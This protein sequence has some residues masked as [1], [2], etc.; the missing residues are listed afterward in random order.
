MQPRPRISVIIPTF[1]SGMFLREAVVSVL[2]QRGA[3]VEVI[4]VDDASTDGGIET[5]THLER[6]T[7]VRLPHNQGAAAAQNIGL[8]I[9]SG[10][11]ITFLDS[12]DR[13]AEN[14]LGWRLDWIQTRPKY[15]VV[16]GMAAGILDDRG[17]VV[18]DFLH[19]NDVSVPER[20]T[21]QFYSSG[22]HYPVASWLYLFRKDLVDAVGPFDESLR[23]AYD[24]DFLL[25]VLDKTDIPMVPKATVYRRIHAA[26]ISVTRDWEG[27][28]L[29]SDTIEECRRVLLPRGIAPP[30]EWVPWETGGQ[31]VG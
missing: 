1:N 28:H 30:A 12:D 29:R 31:R 2:E 10:E 17:I 23:I 24:F 20:L 22:K 18:D 27:L 13:M 8:R 14:S 11:W 16:G 19:K 15:P 6:V 7:I 9:A 25:R 3:G 26:N 5:L 21:Q 4:V